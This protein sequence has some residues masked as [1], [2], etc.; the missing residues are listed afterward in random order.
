MQLF[1]KWLLLFRV[2]KLACCLA[3]LLKMT[4]ITLLLDKLECLFKTPNVQRIDLYTQLTTLFEDPTAIRLGAVS[5]GVQAC[6]RCWTADA[7]VIGGMDPLPD[8][9]APMVVTFC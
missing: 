8:A 4:I 9:A 6:G 1:F 3:K 5:T 7:V 2:Y